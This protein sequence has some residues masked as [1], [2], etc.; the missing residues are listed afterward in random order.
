MEAVRWLRANADTYLID[1]T[2]IGVA[3]A[4]GTFREVTTRSN[5]ASAAVQVLAGVGAAVTTTV[6]VAVPAAPRRR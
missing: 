3:D 2:R 1:T 4:F 5:S 6:R